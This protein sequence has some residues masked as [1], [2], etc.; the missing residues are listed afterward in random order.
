ME[1]GNQKTPRM[2]SVVDYGLGDFRTQEINFRKVGAVAG[3]VAPTMSMYLLAA[4]GNPDTPVQNAILAASYNFCY[5][6]PIVTAV[7]GYAVGETFDRVTGNLPQQRRK[8][9]PV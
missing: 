3:A 4:H 7:L 6:V 8:V 2:K 1:W 9:Y 5:P